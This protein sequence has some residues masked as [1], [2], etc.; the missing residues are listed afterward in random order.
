MTATAP[1]HDSI[2][3]PV[4]KLPE[5]GTTIFTVMSRL[6]TE[7]AAI[8]LSQGF[9][10]FE[11]PEA[12]IDRVAYHLRHGGNQYAPMAGAP[13]L[14][15][16]IA[17]KCEAMYGCRPAWAEEVTVTV[18]GTEGLFSTIQALVHPG[19]EVI[20]LDPAY[21]A[22]APAVHLAG[23]S[24][25]RV[26][27]VPP[28]FHVDWDAVHNAVSDRTRLLMLN[29]PHNPT[30]AILE[31]EDMLALRALLRRTSLT[32][33]SDEVYEHMVF[34][35]QPHRSLLRYPELAS[36]AVVV[37]SFGK[38]CHC[39]GWKIGYCVAPAPITDEIRK[40]HQFVPFAVSTPMQLALADFTR[41]HPEHHLGLPDFYQRKRDLFVDLLKNSRFAVTPARA[42]YFQL[43]DYRAI[44]DQDD[45][46]FARYLT[47]Q[48]GVAAIPLSPFG[49]RADGGLVR[50]CFAKDDATLARAAEKLCRL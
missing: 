10:D 26:G 45:L 16:A 21:D 3:P 24:V 2:P 13:T 12:L 37:S 15:Q 46:S 5:V 41:A 33:V 7:H 39:T 11:P 20:V 36:R 8:N 6:A 50:F 23:G 9:P 28:D 47:T 4:S 22:Y 25:R 48:V 29:F 17:E 14:C 19:D 43:A 34:D 49:A 38:T 1:G 18:G 42:T 32:V 30:G 44:S 35:G 27:L 31:D 40:V